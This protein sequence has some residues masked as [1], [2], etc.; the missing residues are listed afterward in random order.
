MN[1]LLRKVFGAFSGIAFF[2][3]LAGSDRAK[4]DNSHPGK[5]E[6]LGTWELVSTRYGDAKDFTD[7]PG[8]PKRLKIINDTHFIWVEVTGMKTTGSAGGHYT[9][10]G[11]KYVETIEFAM[12][13]ME[14][15]VGKPQRFTVK[16]TGD[17]FFQ[18]GELS[19]GF[20]IEENWKRVR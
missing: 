1:P 4:A 7:Y 17:K 13:G 3:L 6:L 19:T 8:E 15:F 20:K 14:P 5:S 11:D 16:V 12:P 9:L 18:S 2:L 10:D